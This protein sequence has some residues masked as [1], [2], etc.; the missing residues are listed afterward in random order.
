MT[1]KE[2]KEQYMKPIVYWWKRGEA[3]LYIGSSKRGLGRMIADSHKVMHPLN[4]EDNDEIGFQYFDSKDEALKTE[5]EWLRQAHPRYNSKSGRA[6][7]YEQ[8]Q[9]EALRKTELK[10]Y[11]AVEIGET[12]NE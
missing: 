5:R 6:N 2:F 3:W 11:G 1:G 7:S 9:V 8:L 12:E 4:I 10:S